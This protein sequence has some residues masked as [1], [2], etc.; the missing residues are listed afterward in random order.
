MDISLF[1]IVFALL[2]GL[3]VI[4]AL[5]V[6]GA[7]LALPTTGGALFCFTHYSKIETILD[8]INMKSNDVVFDLGCGDGRFI[9][10][11]AKR[12]NIKGTGF[13]INFFAY[14]LA[15]LRLF[16]LRG[17]VL[18]KRDS[19]WK[20]DFGEADVIFCY[21]FPDIME[22]VAGKT[23]KEMKEGALLISCNFPLPGWCAEKVLTADHPSQK[24]P[25]YIYRKKA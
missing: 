2:G 10:S 11:A 24:D 4:K 14:F 18:V 9:A 16:P 25:I 3:V 13:E 22:K 19:F 20:A 15:R 21:L 23:K 8:E 7:V 17:R 1:W 12:Y 5:Y 6:L